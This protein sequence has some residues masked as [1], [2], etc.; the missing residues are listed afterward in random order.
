MGEN[1]LEKVPSILKKTDQLR[2]NKKLNSPNVTVNIHSNNS[3]FLSHFVDLMS[4]VRL[5]V[6]TVRV[7]KNP[8]ESRKKQQNFVVTGGKRTL[9]NDVVVAHTITFC[10][11][12][13]VLHHDLSRI[14]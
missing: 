7:K 8:N 11:T 6:L 2:E 10:T 4:S 9:R 1:K 5:I 14:K 13:C 12:I 3:R